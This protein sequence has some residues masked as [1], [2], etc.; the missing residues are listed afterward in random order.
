MNAK[1]QMSE[2]PIWKG[3]LSFWELPFIA[4]PPF[5]LDTSSCPPDHC[6]FSY[7]ILRSYLTA[8][9]SAHLYAA[10]LI[11]TCPPFCC[12]ALTCHQ[13]APGDGTSTY[14][15]LFPAQQLAL[16][17]SKTVVCTWWLDD[18]PQQSHLWFLFTESELQ[19]LEETSGYH[20]VQYPAK[21][22]SL[23]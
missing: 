5:L 10:H 16:V 22:G 8:M 17:C 9:P 7:P 1:G 13:A 15:A 20:W 19:G 11:P 3:H 14:W 23:Q 6:H 4:V 21:A 2:W 18:R 12:I